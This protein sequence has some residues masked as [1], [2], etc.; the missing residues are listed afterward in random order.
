[1]FKIT[2]G[3]GCMFAAA[4]TASAS[5]A[6]TCGE[7]SLM[8][9]DWGSAQIVTA[10]S[11]FLMEQGYGCDVTTVPLTTNPAMVSVAETGEPDILTE[12]WTNGAPAYKGLVDC[13][14]QSQGT[15]TR[16]GQRMWTK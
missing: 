13:P 10:V 3:L 16:A 8:Q 1:M 11:K 12:I 15:A 5:K 7:V 6:E 14:D 9:G 2:I 4:I